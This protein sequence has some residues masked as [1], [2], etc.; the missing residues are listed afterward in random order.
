MEQHTNKDGAK[1][2]YSEIYDMWLKEKRET[3]WKET[4]ESKYEQ[5]D[6]IDAWE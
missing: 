5:L 6:E 4:E 3:K 1:Y 2:E